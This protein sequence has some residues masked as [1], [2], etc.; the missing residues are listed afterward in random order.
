MAQRCKG[1]KALTIKIDE[2][3]VLLAVILYIIP[4]QSSDNIEI[5]SGL[6]FE[7]ELS[8]ITIPSIPFL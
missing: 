8:Y 1:T 2:S 4:A 7:E 6:A 5:D 3:P